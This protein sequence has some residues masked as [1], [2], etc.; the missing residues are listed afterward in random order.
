MVSFAGGLPTPES[1]PPLGTRGVPRRFLQYGPSEG[2]PELRRFIARDLRR[3][4]LDCG[5]G[6]VLVL[7]GSQ[8]GI[9]LA[10]KL[11]IDPGSVVAV[12]SPTYLAALQV[13]RFFGAAFQ[14][15]DM[16]R[17]GLGP[18]KP[19]LSYINPT[20]QNPTGRC[21]P[22]EERRALALE[23]DRRGVP[24]FEDDPYRDLAFGPCDRTPVASLLRKA[25]WIYQGS[26]SKTLAPGLRIGYLAASP[27]LVRP[28]TRLKQAADLHTNRISQWIVLQRLR[29]GGWE[30]RAGKLAGIYRG[31]R[32][33]FA[34][35]LDRHFRGMADW[36]VPEGGLF[37]WLRLKKRLD[38]RRLFPLALEKGVTFMPGEHFFAERRPPA[39][40]LRLNFSHASPA[41]SERGLSRLAGLVGSFN[42]SGP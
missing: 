25:D 29:D 37:F 9:D 18:R 20:F 19:V 26:Y 4:G 14:N 42:P 34:D 11:F 35:S 38:T 32:D 6:Q 12:E 8:Q 3:R 27:N 28:L 7:S 24:L 41:E 16:D 31:R 1:F 13:F 22:L 21:L 39:G 23:C 40:Y 2:E 36:S 15:A 33:A 10:A 5:P 30:K 17:G